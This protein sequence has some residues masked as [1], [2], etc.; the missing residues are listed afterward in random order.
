MSMPKT[1]YEA[2]DNKPIII[3]PLTLLKSVEVIS[4]K[5]ME[6]CNKNYLKVICDP[7]LIC[8]G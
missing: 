7:W 8:N 4:L 3:I 5:G 6:V 1:N 2:E